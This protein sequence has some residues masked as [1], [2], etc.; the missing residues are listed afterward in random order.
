MAIT[1]N[2]NNDDLPWMD[3]PYDTPPKVD[4]E[5]K[6]LL[7]I[8]LAAYKQGASIEPPVRSKGYTAVDDNQIVVKQTYYG[9]TPEKLRGMF[10]LKEDGLG[11]INR[12]ARGAERKGEVARTKVSLLGY[13]TIKI[14]DYTY[15]VHK[16]IQLM[17]K[18]E[19]AVYLN[20]LDGN[21]LNVAVSNWVPCSLNES[22][23]K[24]VYL[25]MRAR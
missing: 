16:L 13:Q 19:V 2:N 1:I 15:L 12:R 5:I 8:R 6:E 17:E 20:P 9:V 11:F 24:E 7:E 21:R 14:K 22:I 4:K 23:D 18:G 25:K 10:D 3:T